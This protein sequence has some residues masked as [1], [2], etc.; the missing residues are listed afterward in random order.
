[1]THARLALFDPALVRP[2]LIDSLRKLDPRVISFLLQ[3][4]DLQT[5]AL[6]HRRYSRGRATTSGVLAMCWY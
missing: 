4:G 2:A 6:N 3:T 1:M 5:K